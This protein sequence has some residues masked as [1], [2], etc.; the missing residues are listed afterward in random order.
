M[1]ADMY[2]HMQVDDPHIRVD[3][4]MA[5]HKMIRLI[6]LATAGAGY[7]NFMGNEFGHPE[8]V[9]FPREGNNWTYHYARRQWHLADDPN[10]KY[11][12]N[13]DFDRDMIALAK[14][15]Q[16]LDRP[17]P[18][19]VYEHADNK[20]LIFMRAGLLFAF[21]FHPTRSYADYRFE[22]APGKYKLIFTSDAAGYGGHHRLLPDQEHLAAPEVIDR[23]KRHFLSLYLPARTAQVL[24]HTFQGLAG[25]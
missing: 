2:D 8:W 17:A 4:G 16:L 23:H 13:A 1:N 15:F 7:L 12:F 14:K 21:N 3:R 20:L 6:T 5:L 22:A 24:Q 19:L 11:K 25:T 18:H 9:D 10:L